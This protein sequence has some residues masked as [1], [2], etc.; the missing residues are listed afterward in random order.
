VAG[1][2]GALIDGQDTIGID[3]LL[4]P[5]EEGARPGL[6]RR[7]ALCVKGMRS[8]SGAQCPFGG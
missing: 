7:P 4:E 3:L 1:A 6:G 5:R 8:G 2:A